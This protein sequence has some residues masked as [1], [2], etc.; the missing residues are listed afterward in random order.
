MPDIPTRT[1]RVNCAWRSEHE[2]EVPADWEMISAGDLGA[3]LTAMQKVE[4]GADITAVTAELVDW[5]V[6]W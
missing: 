1:V 3:L 4:P 5:D 2:V 6:V